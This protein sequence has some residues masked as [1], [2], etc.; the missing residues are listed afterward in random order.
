MIEC[1]NLSYQTAGW[2]SCFTFKAEQEQW[3][4]IAGPSGSG[5]STLL[6]LLIGFLSAKEGELTDQGKSIQ[7]LPPHARNMNYMFQ[8]STLLPHFTCAKN[9]EIAL[10]DDPG[11]LQLK[12]E[13]IQEALKTAALSS[14]LLNRLPHE[15]SGG[16]LARMNLARTLLRP[17]RWILL[18][19]PFAALD[20]DL[21]LKILT[22]LDHW[23][24]LHRVGV[25]MVSHD[26]S[27][28]MLMADQLLFIDKGRVAG[29]GRPE[30]LALTPTSIA[31]AKLLK[32]G[33]VFHHDNQTVFIAPHNL[34]TSV[35]ELKHHQSPNSKTEYITHACRNWR[36]VQ[37]GAAQCVIDLDED[38][39]WLLPLDRKFSGLFYFFAH[40]LH[41]LKS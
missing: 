35:E 39:F 17:C 27:D 16:E 13:K 34:F 25:F 26:P 7:R 12:L 18:D 22:N 8:Q 3:T 30:Q 9:L 40:S 2:G 23:R 31:M 33:S 38:Q 14:E 4:G 11:H 15:L 19:E 32:T 20:A 36:T 24:R 1:K 21:R 5:K 37:L 41:N 28:A 10:H 29:A 6:S